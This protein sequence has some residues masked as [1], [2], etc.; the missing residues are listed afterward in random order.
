MY[1]LKFKDKRSIVRFLG[2]IFVLAIIILSVGTLRIQATENLCYESYAGMTCGQD[3]ISNNFLGGTDFL[4]KY[5]ISGIQIPDHLFLGDDFLREAYNKPGEN[6]IGQAINESF[7]RLAKF[8][9]LALIPYFGFFIV[10]NVISRIKNWKGF[11]LNFDSILILSCT[12]IMLLPALYAYTRGIDEIRY[13]LVALPLF[14]IIS[15][16]WNKSVSEKILK[17]RSIIVILIVLILISS[18]T[19]IE[20]NKRDS[21]LKKFKRWSPTKIF[22]IN[23]L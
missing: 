23:C 2:M 13:V 19:F 20:F 8:L 21:Y 12:G 6:D 16:S 17:N 3:G 1:F 7:S 9:G 14:C 5:I 22:F 18:I 11:G 15:L 10:F 4:Q